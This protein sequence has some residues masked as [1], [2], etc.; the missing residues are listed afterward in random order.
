MKCV[1][2]TDREAEYVC[3]SCGQ[4]VCR[5]CVTVI[6][7]K[8]VCKACGQKN[9]Q[10]NLS[11]YNHIQY[12]KGDGINSFFFFIFLL[13]PGLR[14]MYLGLMNRGLQ[15]LIAF[16]GTIT[17]G[18]FL[19]NSIGEI[20][21]PVAFIIWFY[22]AFDSFQYRKLIARGERVE[23]RPIFEDYST[24]QLKN[25]LGRRKKIVGVSIIILGVYMLLRQFRWYA[26]RFGIPETLIRTIFSVIDFGF[27]SIIPILLIVA[28]MYLLA[29]LRKRETV[30]E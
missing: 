19:G 13:V 30:E 20:V 29:G 21:I 18:M 9:T 15:L 7:G 11:Q 27:D 3:S 25:L 24:D 14:H 23:D 2:H 1:Y 4:P 16:F 17:I 5:E 6:N 26:S 8:N 10:Y 12:K 22:S 28:G